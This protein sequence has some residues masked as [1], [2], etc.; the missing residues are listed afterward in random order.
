MREG[1]QKVPTW[2]FQRDIYPPL[3]G[4]LPGLAFHIQIYF[5]RRSEMKRT[6]R[7][8]VKANKKG[9]FKEVGKHGSIASVN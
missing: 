3:G 7:Y 1:F 5:L 9:K 4:P 6:I 8:W 2:R